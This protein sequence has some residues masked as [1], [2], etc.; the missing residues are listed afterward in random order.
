MKRW[1]AV[2]LIA[3]SSGTASASP[4]P[5]W[6]NGGVR[7]DLSDDPDWAY[8]LAEIKYLHDGSK[9]VVFVLMP[10]AAQQ[11]CRLGYSSYYRRVTFSVNGEA[12]RG[13]VRCSS[14]NGSKE[15]HYVFWALSRQGVAF[16]VSALKASMSITVNHPLLTF[17]LSAMGFT[18]AWDRLGGDDF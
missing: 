7:M 2:L 8:A 6:N 13:G 4:L 3:L 18:N 16:I 9:A 14:S 17:E 1:I 5:E 10:S 11:E 12:I 15:T